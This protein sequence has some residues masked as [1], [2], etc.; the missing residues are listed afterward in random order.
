[1][2]RLRRILAGG[3]L[4]AMLGTALTASGCKSTHNPVP[5]GPKYGAMGEPPSSAGFNSD[6]H[7]YSAMPSPYAN[8]P[9]VGGMPQ[10]GVPGSPGLGGGS[11]PGS[12]ADGMPP[13][14]GSGG[15]QSSFGTPTPGSPGMGL[16][17]PNAYGGPGTSG[18]GR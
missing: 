8:G 12:P 7:P 11:A 9:A 2:D 15:G 18:M 16:P 17:T 4:A 13:G 1:M 3:A 6:P 14:L 10:Q 5:P